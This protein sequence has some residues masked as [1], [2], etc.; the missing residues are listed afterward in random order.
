MIIYENIWRIR[1]IKN[2][3]VGRSLILNKAQLVTLR[4]N[5]FAET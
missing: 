1:E 3:Q 5:I 2:V 4:N